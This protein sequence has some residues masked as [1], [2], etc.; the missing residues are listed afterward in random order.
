MY[1]GGDLTSDLTGNLTM[2]ILYRR[3]L[4]SLATQK[5]ISDIATD[6]FHYAKLRGNIT[7]VS[8]SSLPAP[9]AANA[10]G[11]GKDKAGAGGKEK[12]AEKDKNRVV[13]TMDD[14]SLALGDHGIKSKRPDYCESA[15]SSR[16]CAHDTDMRML[17]TSDMVVFRSYM[18]F[19]TLSSY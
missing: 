11:K 10:Q 5:F 13:L 8:N 17:Q 19:T 14:L 3:N 1:S 18:T 2:V 9:S 12:A 6:A 15:M 7:G 4:L 16:Q